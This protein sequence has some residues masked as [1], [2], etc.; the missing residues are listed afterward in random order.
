MSAST[1]TIQAGKLARVSPDFHITRGL[2]ETHTLTLLNSSGTA[3]PVTGITGWVMQVAQDFLTTTPPFAESETILSDTNVLPVTLNANTT[4]LRD[5]MEGKTMSPVFATLIGLDSGGIPIRSITF[6]IV[7]LNS[8]YN[9]EAEPTPV[10]AS[11]FYTAAQVDVKFADVAQTIGVPT[12]INQLE[13]EDGL[14][15]GKIEAVTALPAPVV[16]ILNRSYFLTDVD[17]E[18]AKGTIWKCVADGSAYDWEQITFVGGGAEIAIAQCTGKGIAYGEESITLNWIDPEDVVLNGAILAY[19]NKTVLIRKVDSYPESITD[20]VQIAETSRAEVTKNHYRDNPVVDDTVEAGVSY[21]YKLFSQTTVGTWNNLDGNCYATATALS[22]SMWR[23]FIRANNLEQCPQ[24]G[25]MVAVD[26]GEYGTIMMRVA[27]YDTHQPNDETLQHMALLECEDILFNAVFDAPESVYGLTF[28]TE[29]V[30]GKR[31]YALI[32]GAYTMLVEGT[33][34]QIGDNE[35]TIGG[36]A[37][38]ISEWY[39]PHNST[40]RKNN[41]SNRYSQSNVD[42]GLN[43]DYLLNAATFVRRNQWDVLSSTWHRNGLLRYI[44]PEFKNCLIEVRL[45]VNLANIDGAGNEIIS[46]KVFLPSLTEIYGGSVSEGSQYPYYVGTASADKIKMLN[47]AVGSWWLRSP[48]GSYAVY[49][50]F[51]QASGASSTNLASYAYG[52]SSAFA[53][54]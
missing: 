33:D 18:K 49:A 9:P 4:E 25:D 38:P 24:V 21:Y 52:V 40:E 44:E 51:V 17:G 5:F 11:Q 14:L 22:W 45:I 29:A 34:Y 42:L 7:V 35:A 32:G 23:T 3:Y 53:L 26:H 41:G 15:S 36:Y 47:G 12:D 6:R 2:T 43:A 10:Q 13:D 37:Y 54:G 50:S 46:R 30:A 8:N 31:Y 19:W 1:I 28:D 39:N 16:G 20:G 27:G 48:H